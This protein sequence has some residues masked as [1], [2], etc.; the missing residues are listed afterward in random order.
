M[1]RRRRSGGDVQGRHAGGERS[2][3][4]E[5]REEVCD[6]L[7]H[8]RIP[9]AGAGQDAGE[10]DAAG[11]EHLR[12]AGRR[13]E[14]G[15][16]LV[17]G[18]E[19]GVAEAAG[20]RL[21]PGRLGAVVESLIALVLVQT[22]H[23]RLPGGAG[24]RPDPRRRVLH[25]ERSRSPEP[26]AVHR[27]DHPVLGP[28]H[29]RVAP[30]AGGL[31]RVDGTHRIAIAVL[32]VAEEQPAAAVRE[33]H[34]P[35]GVIGREESGVGPCGDGCFRRVPHGARPVLA[36]SL[37]DEQAAVREESGIGVEVRVGGVR[38]VVALSFDEGD[39]VAVLGE[40]LSRPQ[41]VRVGPVEG[42]GERMP[43]RRRRAGGAPADLV[44][45]QARA[46]PGVVGLIRVGRHRVEDHRARRAFANDEW[47]QRV[48]FGR[49]QLD[50]IDAGHR[51]RRDGER[52]RD[53]PGGAHRSGRRIDDVRRLG[54][55][56]CGSSRGNFPPQRPA[57]V[58]HAPELPGRVGRPGD[59]SGAD[60]D[61]V[62][63][64]I[65]GVVGI[66]VQRGVVERALPAAAPG[67]LVFYGDG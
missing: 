17:E 40:E 52:E 65:A 43:G 10:A 59:E 41:A 53:R 19:I 12:A 45:V 15:L 51:A 67:Q 13:I 58:P 6:H 35:V 3:A 47:D 33:P 21:D 60:G 27:A 64:E 63:G 54:R 37:D 30:Q 62:P 2:V 34:L 32:L 18:S 23:R 39:E 5:L 44:D 9:P 55:N 8:E 31:R 11:L 16:R 28:P 26:V 61:L 4:G 29:R 46:S 38:H 48:A 7:L 14:R 24:A 66:A 50:H 36:V 57:V 42:D 49:A 20:H 25:A 56:G 1:D 22:R